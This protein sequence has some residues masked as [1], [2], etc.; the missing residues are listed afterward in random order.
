MGFRNFK[1]KNL[2]LSIDI[3]WVGGSS[4]KNKMLVMSCDSRK[5]THFEQVGGRRGAQTRRPSSPR[6]ERRQ[7]FWM[8]QAI[9]LAPSAAHSDPCIL[10]APVS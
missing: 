2:N 4:M 10:R 3:Y 7:R 9:V 6:V 5:F 8:H 1:R